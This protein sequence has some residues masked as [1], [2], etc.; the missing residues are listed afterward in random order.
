MGAD[1]SQAVIDEC[2]GNAHPNPARVRELVELHPGR[3][4]QLTVR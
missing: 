1:L 4:L 3:S 2:L